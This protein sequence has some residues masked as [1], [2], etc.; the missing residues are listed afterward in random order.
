M[1][2]GLRTIGC[3]GGGQLGMMMA[4]AAHRL[5][6]KMAILDPGGKG[7]PAGQVDSA[8]AYDEL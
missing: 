8:L 5:G 7:S 1:D 3:L 6:V 4:A 2:P